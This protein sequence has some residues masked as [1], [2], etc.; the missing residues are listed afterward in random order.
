MGIRASAKGEDAMSKAFDVEWDYYLQA[1]RLHQRATRAANAEARRTL[2]AA[3]G[4]AQANQRDFPRAY[5]LLSFVILTAWLN[6]WIAC[7]DADALLAAATTD[8]TDHGKRQEV[9][10]PPI[11]AAVYDV[12]ALKPGQPPSEVVPAL[13]TYYAA[14][15]AGLGDDDYDNHWSLG[16]A[17][18][19]A[20]KFDAFSAEYDKATALAGATYVP[21]ICRLCLQ[22]DVADALFFAVPSGSIADQAAQFKLAVATTRKA[23]DDAI[24]QVADDPKRHRWNWTLGWAHYEADEL[25]ESLNALLTFRNPHDLICKNIIATYAADGQLDAAS[26]YVEDFRARNPGYTL[27]VEDRWPYRDPKRLERWKGHLRKAGLPDKAP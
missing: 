19:Y 24:A 12:M 4:A 1:F 9:A 23:M 17:Y 7:A 3:L 27:A 16:T 10:V 22:V 26:P 21:V 18:L 6:D 5:G 25:A 2:Q 11:A 8:I 20:K 13:V 15:A 14:M